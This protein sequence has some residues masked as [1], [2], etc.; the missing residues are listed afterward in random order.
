MAGVSRP[1]SGEV[2]ICGKNLR[3]NVEYR[4]KIG[5]LTHHS[6]LYEDLTA[7]EN[8]L[9]YSKL[10]CMKDANLKIEYYL[11][12]MDLT[13]WR[14]RKINGFSRG[15]RQRLSIARAIIHNPSVVLLDEPYS[16]LDPT[17]R[18]TLQKLLIELKTHG[19]T[20]LMATHRLEDAAPLADRV[21]VIETGKIIIDEPWQGSGSELVKLF[22]S[23]KEQTL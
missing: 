10:Y 17:A 13:R 9:F 2:F 14:H 12:L 20:F 18:E 15:M 21:I 23:R 6:M 16:G 5:L 11:E 1:S 22:E 3:T 4:A 7:E 19:H 8:L